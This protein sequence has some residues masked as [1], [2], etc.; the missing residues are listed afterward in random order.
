MSFYRTYVPKTLFFDAIF[1]LKARQ[2]AHI[3]ARIKKNNNKCSPG[4]P[5]HSRVKK[6]LKLK[7]LVYHHSPERQLIQRNKQLSEKG[8]CAL[9]RI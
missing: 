3:S 7:F 5:L 2:R 6:Y 4:F 1:S 9:F 8:V